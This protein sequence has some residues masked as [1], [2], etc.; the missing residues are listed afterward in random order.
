MKK[1]QKLNLKEN[2]PKMLGMILLVIAALSHKHIGAGSVA[3]LVVDGLI[4]LISDNKKAKKE[5]N[6]FVDS[7]KKLDKRFAFVALCDIL[8]IAVFFLIIPLL[9]SSFISHVKP[10]ASVGGLFYLIVKFFAYFAAVTLIL[11]AAYSFSRNFIWLII[12]KKKKSAVFFKKFFLLN[13]A[14][15]L[16]LLVPALIFFGARSEYFIYLI[17]FFVAAYIHFTT[18]L[19]YDFALNMRIGHAIKKSFKLTF[20]SLKK[21]LLPYAYVTLVYFILLQVFWFIP[22]DDKIMFFASILFVVFFMAWFRFYM[23]GV[24]KRIEHR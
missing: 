24:L 8:F 14:W 17:L 16:I 6:F 18:L 11:L 4:L 9:S 2:I 10:V 23:S 13:L 22:A 20:V 7:F 15:W 21:F 5:F 12:L 19:H 3:V 1:R